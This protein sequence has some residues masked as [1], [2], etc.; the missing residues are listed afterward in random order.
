MWRRWA[1]LAWA[2]VLITA[3]AGCS[4]EEID[5]AELSKPGDY[6]VGATVVEAVD[7]SR[8]DRPLRIRV[9]YPA[10]TDSEAGEPDAPAVM[11]GAP[12]PVIVGD[13]DISRVMGPHLASHGFAFVA[14]DG[15]HTWGLSL[16]PDMIDFPLDQMAALDAIEDLADGLVVGVC[17]TSTVG[18]IGYSFGGW[19][20]LMLTGARI[21]PNHYAQTCAARPDSWTDQW[22][23]YICGSAEGWDQLEQR[24][25]DVGIATDSGLW[26][27]IGDERIKAAMP[28][29]AEGYDLTGPDGLAEATA[30]VLLVGASEDTASDYEP[31]TTRLFENY[32]NAELITFMGADHF[33]IFEDDAVEQ[34]RRFAVAFFKRQLNGEDSYSTILSESFVENEAAL[35]G[36][37]E[38]Y[39]R[40]VWGTP[41]G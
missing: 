10:Q 3:T 16:S 13:I 23:D 12:Y 37:T 25:V 6:G 40:L 36:E 4:T 27:P 39:D 17:D 18:T 30:D 32:P 21:D 35:L 28:M 29:A 7:A 1:A 38:S 20:A 22:W 15:Q 14:L 34:M 41:N 8:D 2:L 24:A 31:A 33:M 11:G 5:A 9:F 19:D 26:E